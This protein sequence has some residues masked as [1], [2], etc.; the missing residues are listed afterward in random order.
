MQAHDMATE[1]TDKQ[2]SVRLAPEVAARAD[3]LIPVLRRMEHYS[4]FRMER[5]TVFRVAL[6]R[7]LAV[8]EREAADHVTREKENA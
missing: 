6:V 1:D 8:L 2:Y 5:S 4:A 3:A 7:G